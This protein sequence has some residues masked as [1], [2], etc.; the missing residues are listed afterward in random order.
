LPWGKPHEATGIHRISRQQF[1]RLAARGARA[2]AEGADHWLFGRGVAVSLDPRVA[3]FVQRLREL[4][5]IEGRTVAIDYRWAEGR[6]ER[7]AEIVSEFDLLKVDVIVTAGTAPVLAAKQATS[8]IPIVFALA[9]DP[10]SSGLVTS[11]ARPGGNITGLSILSSELAGKRLEILRE[12]VPRVR[13]LA[14]LS[15]ADNPGAVMEREEV[16]VAA[17]MLDLDVTKLDIR[18]AEDIPL[19]FDGLRDRVDALYVAVDPL[20]NANRI[21][22]NTL[23][24]KARLPTIHGFRGYV[25]TGGLISYGADFPDMWRRAA[26]YVDKTLRGIKPAEIPVEQ[27]TKFELVINLKTAKALGL[28]VPWFLQQR[29]DEVIE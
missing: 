26:D 4:G 21:R 11:L 5:W 9:S 23:A 15:N 7:Y 2:A 12:L 13:N 6:N 18:R 24:L 8:T 1:S 20:I 22:I 27:A 17:R 25:E 29:A 16:L 3:A 28:D 10:V 19:A 14:I